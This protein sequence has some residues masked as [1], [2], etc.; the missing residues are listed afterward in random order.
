[1]LTRPP[2]PVHLTKISTHS[3]YDPT[4]ED[5]YSVTRTIDGLPYFLSLT[6][7]AGQEEYR[8]LWAASNLQSDAFLLVYDITN[9]SSLD[10]L[11]YFMDMID[12]EEENRI[13]ENNRAILR[14]VKGE[15]VMRAPPVKI[16][17]GNKCDLKD[18]RVVSSRAGLE[19]ARKRRCGF[20]ETSAREMV[21]IEE[22]FACKA[23]LPSW[24][25][26]GYVLQSTKYP[27][28]GNTN[29]PL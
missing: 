2:C 7:T 20:M 3:R 9:T 8:G 14:G 17:A 16:V 12:I 6:D 4:I 24:H 18:S 22:T 5:S 13:E 25:A 28:T 26:T 27:H 21:N 19:W 23:A 10:A 15:K 29:T 11:D 1:V